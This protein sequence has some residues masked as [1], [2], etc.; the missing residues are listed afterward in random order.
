MD[1]INPNKYGKLKESA[2]L[3]FEKYIGVKLPIEYR[4]YQLEHNGGKPFPHDFTISKQEGDD[5]IHHFYGLHS[6]PD[7][8]QL[9]SHYDTYCDRMPPEIIPIADDPFGN[10][11]CIGIK[12]KY[13]EKIYFWDHEKESG[14]SNWSNIKEIASSFDQFL[15]SLFEYIDPNET[16]IEK[17]IR[18]NNISGLLK[19]IDN[20]YDIETLYEYD[21][22]L[23]EMAAIHANNEMV[24]ILFRK[25]AKL[26]HALKYAEQNAQFFEKHK[27]TVEL[28]KRLT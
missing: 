1:I 23:I 27:E 16:Y 25:G 13:T 24:E 3:N 18:T 14:Q 15:N 21:R 22:S 6:G 12:G 8:L 7:Y 17:I 11:I 28:I 10:Q 5:S 19:L 20:G 4:K 2:L 26:R 9:R